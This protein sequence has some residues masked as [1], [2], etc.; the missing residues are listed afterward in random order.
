MK[1]KVLKI[2]K[3]ADSFVSGQKMCESLGVSRTAVWKGVKALEKDG[4][5]ITSIQNKGYKLL[6]SPDF[7]D[8][9]SISEHLNTKIIGNKILVLESVDSTNNYAK[10][11][12]QK[13]EKEGLS[14]VS[15]EQTGGKGRLGRAWKSKKDETISLSVSLKPEISPLEIGAI[16]PLAGLAVSNAI[17]NVTGIDAK[18]KWPNDVIYENKKIC[19]ILT[20]MNC[21]FDK[22]DFIVIGI[23]INCLNKDFP[24][25]IKNKATSLLLI[26]N[27]SIDLNC[28]C[29]E[30]MNELEK[31]LFQNDFHFT[32][33]S[34]K[35]YKSRCATLNK[36]VSYIRNN[37]SLSGVATDISSLGELIVT[38]ENGEK[39]T[40]F[41]GEVTV[42]GIY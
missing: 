31:V 25:E 34:L 29:A 17:K 14:V 22:V 40:V 19:G 3:E 33:E 6:D 12:S 1:E 42:Q 36:T 41:S 37:R 28:L 24:K 9:N 10:K 21:E 13:G 5:K 23:G 4:Y 39:E 27:K 18:I 15:R 2:L 16:T 8:K 26:N 35:E 7:L 32:D 30:V 38:K 20:E 11:L